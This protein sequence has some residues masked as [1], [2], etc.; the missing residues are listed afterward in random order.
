M[1]A[2]AAALMP[3]GG[4]AQGNVS[5]SFLTVPETNLPGG[6]QVRPYAPSTPAIVRDGKILTGTRGWSFPFPGNPWVGADRRLLIELR[7][8]I[9][10]P[11]RFPDAPPPSAAEVSTL[12]RRWVADVLEGYRATYTSSDGTSVEVSAIRFKDRDLAEA[13]RPAVGPRGAEPVIVGTAV[14]LVS[15]DAKSQCF[16]AIDRYTRTLK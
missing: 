13:G 7:R 15:G 9:N 10:G 5:L 16:R 2:I 4:S 6:C 1:S 11:L 14:V 3:A 8:R 12:E